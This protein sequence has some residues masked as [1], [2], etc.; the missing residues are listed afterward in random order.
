MP[1]A[2]DITGQ[3]FNFLTALKKEESKKGKT[4]WLFQCDCGN[5]KIL[6]AT[7]VKNGTVKS[8][9]CGLA[10]PHENLQDLVGEKFGRLTVI[11]QTQKPEGVKNKS[12]YWECKCDCGNIH[13]VSTPSLRSGK[14][15]SCGCLNREVRQQQFSK[16]E[17]GNKYCDLIVIAEAENKNFSGGLRWVCEC[18][19]GN[20]IE[21]SGGNLRAGFVTHCGCKT[22]T[23]A[24]ER[25]IAQLLTE[26]NINYKQQYI[27]EDFYFPSGRHPRFDFAILSDK[28][29]VIKLIEFDGKQHFESID[30]FGGQDGFESRVERD[31]IKENYCKKNNI[32]LLRI[33]YLQY[34]SLK[35]E[36][37]L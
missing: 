6:Q 17:I 36:D 11:K 35:I 2:L 15:Q 4:Y 16:N 31:R 23:S 7:Q 10:R 13:I 5:Q 30:F 9:G 3:K 32:P 27:F 18:S 24:G 29:E 20:K 34:N 8:C 22:G 25:K 37:L 33:S 19:C 1:K 12:R 28:N 26:N 21:V 14:V